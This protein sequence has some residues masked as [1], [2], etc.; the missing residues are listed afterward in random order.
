MD[1]LSIEDFTGD[2]PILKEQEF[3]EAVERY[4]WDE[5][6]DKEVLVKGCGRMVIPAWAYMVVAT[7]LQKVASAIY[8]GDATDPTPIWNREN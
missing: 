6:Q 5:F 4:S 7:R 8:F 3:R 2:A 1:T